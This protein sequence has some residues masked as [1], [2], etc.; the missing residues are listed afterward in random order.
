LSGVSASL[1][2]IVA[3]CTSSNTEDTPT[4]A[5]PASTGTGTATP[6]PTARP[7]PTDSPTESASPTPTPTATATETPTA[8]DSPTPTETPTATPTET[9]T[10]TT[11]PTPF[12]RG[13][14][15]PHGVVTGPSGGTI[16]IAVALGE[17]DELHLVV[18]DE[19]AVNFEVSAAVGDGTGDGGV[20]VVFDTDAGGS[21]ATWLRAAD[22]GDPVSVENVVNPNGVETLD[23]ASYDA[24]LY[25]TADGGEAIDVA[26]VAVT[27]STD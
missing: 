3:G 10:P 19:D 24:A 2:A 9:P 17:Y 4:D 26:T 27:S 18:G 8:T 5:A 25:E 14:G 6:T 23:P 16:E 20:T 13:A 7:T 21:D 22:G 11:S 15:F 12:S 1:A